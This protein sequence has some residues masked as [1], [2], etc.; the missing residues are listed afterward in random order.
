MSTTFKFLVLGLVT[1]GAMALSGCAGPSTKGVTSPDTTDL[2][3]VSIEDYSDV[4]AKLDFETGAVVLPL[5]TITLQA[6]EIAAKTQHAIAVLTDAC[7]VQKGFPAV[8]ENR[9]WT[10]TGQE[11]RTFGLWDVDDASKFGFDFDPMTAFPTVE[12]LPLGV[13]YNNNLPECA[14]AATDKLA[15]ELEFLQAPNI[16]YQIYSNA[17]E[18]TISSDEGFEAFAKR[19]ACMEEQD[20][21][22]DPETKGPSDAYLKQSQEIQ[23]RIATVFASCSVDTGAV[24]TLFNIEARFQAA[25]M[26][27]VAAQ[28]AE[29]KTKRLS[30]EKAI[31]GIITGATS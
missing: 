1:T 19:T 23:I 26:D 25:Y 18:Q 17:Y 9:D 7:M 21:V 11:N 27:K 30:T 6:P 29:L 28:I 31:D 20:V 22:V 15:E 14:K 10:W 24:Q 5:S 8:A 3:I 2:G 4:S 12:V 13:E 16:D